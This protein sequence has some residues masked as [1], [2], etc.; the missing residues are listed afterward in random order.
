MGEEDPII[1][2]MIMFEIKSETK[3]EEKTIKMW[4]PC[5]EGDGDDEDMDGEK[6]EDEY[7]Y[8]LVEC[9]QL[10]DIVDKDS[11]SVE[12][13]DALDYIQSLVDYPDCIQSL[14]DYLD[15]SLAEQPDCIQSFFYYPD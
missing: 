9:D 7:E 3:F 6:Y 2:I 14:A 8:D 4:N 13:G 1:M 11:G 10:F 5:G 15:Y 12:L